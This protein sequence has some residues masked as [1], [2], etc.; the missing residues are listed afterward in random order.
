MFMLLLIQIS[1]PQARIPF[2]IKSDG[3]LTLLLN[4]TNPILANYNA[5]I[6]N[7]K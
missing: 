4:Q 2:I 7:Y 1:W 3:Q 5:N 6:M